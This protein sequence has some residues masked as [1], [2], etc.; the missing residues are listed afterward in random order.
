[1]N[2]ECHD[3][4]VP[5]LNGIMAIHSSDRTTDEKALR[6]KKKYLYDLAD[7]MCLLDTH[8]E[9]FTWEFEGDS[10]GAKVPMDAS[11][12]SI[13]DLEITRLNS[14]KVRCI[15]ASMFPRP[16]R[17]LRPLPTSHNPFPPTPLSTSF[18]NLTRGPS[19]T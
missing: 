8:R 4:L 9:C 2:R 15:R 11:A 19:C 18:T 12:D 13:L 1:M 5:A 14:K 17:Y 10:F 6:I 3:V 7:G 16:P